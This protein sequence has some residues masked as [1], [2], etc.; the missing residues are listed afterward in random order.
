MPVKGTTPRLRPSAGP[1][2]SGHWS[3]DTGLVHTR[4]ETPRSAPARSQITHSADDALYLHPR[5]A[6]WA[7][8]PRGGG[9]GGG[10]AG[11]PPKP[12]RRG[13]PSL[14]SSLHNLSTTSHTPRR[15]GSVESQRNP[16]R[17]HPTRF[18]STHPDLSA[19]GGGG[20]FNSQRSSSGLTQGQIPT[21]PGRGPPSPID[22]VRVIRRRLTEIRGPI[23][24]RGMRAA[25]YEPRPFGER[26]TVD[27]WDTCRVFALRYMEKTPTEPEKTGRVTAS[28]I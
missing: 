16:T 28:E 9:G 22:G 10:V 26:P 20:G 7:R 12:R 13:N 8:A 2:Q 5:N 6:R 15:Q 18:P 21:S 4:A 3:R 17:G 1:T 24:A 25:I 19:G 23:P 27:A 11:R 14:R